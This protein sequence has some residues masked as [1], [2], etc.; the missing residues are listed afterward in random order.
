MSR[1]VW[2]ILAGAL[3][4]VA[5]LFAAFIWVSRPTLELGTN[6]M[7]SVNDSGQRDGS[8]EYSATYGVSLDSYTD[9]DMVLTLVFQSGQ[10]DRVI[11]HTLHLVSMSYDS[12]GLILVSSDWTMTLEKN[13]NTSASANHYVAEWSPLASAQGQGHV[14]PSWFGFQTPTTCE[15]SSATLQ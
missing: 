7:M 3:A 9:G 5:L 8:S 14:N 1:R 2:L 11:T 12:D 15:S 13:P 6:G 4:V 10:S